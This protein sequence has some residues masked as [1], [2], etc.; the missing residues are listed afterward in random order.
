MCVAESFTDKSGVTKKFYNGPS[1]DEVALVDF[2]SSMDFDCTLSTDK[3]VKMRSKD[4]N[5]QMQER[6][7]HVY[8]KMDFDSD[9]KRMSVLL[10]D[11]SDGKIKLLIKGADSIIKDRL[12]K[13]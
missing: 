1:P 4:E 6:T 10:K 3:E 12:D 2:A 5:D 9:R 11:E 8:R 13:S 7:Y